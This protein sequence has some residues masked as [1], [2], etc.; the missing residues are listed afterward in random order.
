MARTPSSGANARS[1][2]A[3]HRRRP[4]GA[5]YCLAR[6]R[7][8]AA[9]RHRKFQRLG[10]WRHLLGLQPALGAS[11]SV[12]AS[13]SNDAGSANGAHIGQMRAAPHRRLPAFDAPIAPAHRCT[14]LAFAP[15]PK[16]RHLHFAANLASP[17]LADAGEAASHPCR[18]NLPQRQ[19]LAKATSESV[20]SSSVSSGKAIGDARHPASRSSAIFRF[21]APIL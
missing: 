6:L 3:S 12:S 9:A 14:D 15:G 5:D 8:Q 16:Q 17:G 1:P 11:K 13:P 4:D 7:C 20:L 10:V 18:H 19:A 2:K 21:T